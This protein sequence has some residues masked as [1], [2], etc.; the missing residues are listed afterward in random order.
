MLRNNGE[1]SEARG[2]YNDVDGVGGWL[3]EAT[4]SWA[5]VARPRVR[6]SLLLSWQIAFNFS[7][8]FT[9]SW[10]PPR[11]NWPSSR[12][13]P[14]PSEHHLSYNSLT[15]FR[16][17]WLQKFTLSYRRALKPIAASP[18]H[19]VLVCPSWKLELSPPRACFTKLAYE[20][21]VELPHPIPPREPCPFLKGTQNV[22]SRV[23]IMNA[24]GT[25][26]KPLRALCLHKLEAYY[27][28]AIVRI[29]RLSTFPCTNSV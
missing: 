4:V 27:P 18:P 9:E 11:I 21:T 29:A 24:D 6:V 19:D 2:L 10:Q 23:A 3:W 16:R 28:D 20:A 12:L 7:G 13:H 14:P 1:V 8:L 25:P 26:C 15:F 5:S 22:R 17:L